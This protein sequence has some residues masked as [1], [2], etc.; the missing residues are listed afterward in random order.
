MRDCARDICFIF[1]IAHQKRYYQSLYRKFS[2]M[3]Y[4]NVAESI[5][6]RGAGGPVQPSGPFADH[7]LATS[8]SFTSPRSSAGMPHRL[9]HP[10]PGPQQAGGASH[11]DRERGPP[12]FVINTHRTNSSQHAVNRKQPK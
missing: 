7:V 10:L 9:R 1:A 6:R 5:A 11:R 3:K 4:H 8:D 2:A 12:N